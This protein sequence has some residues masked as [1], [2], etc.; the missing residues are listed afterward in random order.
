MQIPTA[1]QKQK[2]CPSQIVIST[3]IIIKCL[4]SLVVMH[5]HKFML[6]LEIQRMKDVAFSDAIS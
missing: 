6:L 4:S 3:Y 2:N 1:N 5:I